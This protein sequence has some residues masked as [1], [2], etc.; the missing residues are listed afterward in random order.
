MRRV[1]GRHQGLLLL[2]FGF[3]VSV[4]T[5]AASETS[6]AAAAEKEFS[7]EPL[8]IENGSG[9]AETGSGATVIGL[10]E[11]F[12]AVGINV[13]G[14]RRTERTQQY[15]AK[16]KNA[17]SIRCVSSETCGCSYRNSVVNKKTGTRLAR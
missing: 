6:P 13:V 10:A 15:N 4:H 2:I 9:G 7:D 5:A 14:E 11:T 3:A 16:A 1:I 8:P 12:A 17:F